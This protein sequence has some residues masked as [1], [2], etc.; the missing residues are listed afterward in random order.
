MVW[1]EGDG[2]RGEADGGAVSD[3]QEAPGAANQNGTGF[4]SFL[5]TLSSAFSS[6]LLSFPPPPPSPRPGADRQ[7][8]PAS[9]SCTSSPPT[10][11][12]SKQPSG[13]QT[14][15]TPPPPKPRRYD[16]RGKLDRNYSE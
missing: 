1:E 10:T 11:L 6:R 3:K 16:L 12:K 8:L 7:V 5:L 4:L 2:G 9:S 13:G 14:Y 15:D